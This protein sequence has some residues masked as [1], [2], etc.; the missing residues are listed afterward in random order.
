MELMA[1]FF[2]LIQKAALRSTDSYLP[3]A[4]EQLKIRSL[5]TAMAMRGINEEWD[6]IFK[7][8]LAPRQMEPQPERD[9]P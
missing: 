4:P 3:R 8:V 2:M 7:R 6:N 9:H 1:G 5:S